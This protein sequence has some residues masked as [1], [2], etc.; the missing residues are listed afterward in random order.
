MPLANK[1][2]KR[3]TV[4]SCHWF[5]IGFAGHFARPVPIGEP[6]EIE[7]AIHLS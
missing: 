3:F 1:I 2:L 7:E 6:E 4:I 5:C